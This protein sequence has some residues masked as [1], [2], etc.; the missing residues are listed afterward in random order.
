[1]CYYLM[2]NLLSLL[3]ER[4]QFLVGQFEFVQ[5]MLRKLEGL[6][7]GQLATHVPVSS[8]GCGC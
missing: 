4:M 8:A 5:N 2:P 3:G 7:N 1:M 6:Y